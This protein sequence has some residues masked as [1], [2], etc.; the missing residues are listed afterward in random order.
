[1]CL[2]LLLSAST[3][4]YVVVA[5]ADRDVSDRLYCPVGQFG[6]FADPT[7]CSRYVRCAEGRLID[8][9]GCPSDRHWR[10]TSPGYGFCDLPES[11]GCQLTG[12][13]DPLDPVVPV[14]VV[15]CVSS[16]AE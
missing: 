15:T 2:V 3:W 13:S 6:H 5:Q 1:M 9:H 7:N 8:L 10:V 4:I 14:K 11:A 12:V 16:D